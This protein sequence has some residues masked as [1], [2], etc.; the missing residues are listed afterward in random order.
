MRQTI[1]FLLALTML[2]SCKGQDSF[3]ETRLKTAEKFIECL[4][5]NSSDK[6]LDYSYPDIDDKI[7]DK[8][9]R[10]F[11]VNKAYNFIKR[12][13]LPTKDKWIVKYDP[14][15]NFERLIIIIPLF[16]GYDTVFNLLRADIVLTFPPPQISD[17]VYT[18]IIDDD[19]KIKKLNAPQLVDK[20]KRKE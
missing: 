8:E 9:S 19:Y 16:K 6:I 11:Y 2:P 15:N 4:K 3:V 17:K 1:I 13:G 18:Y 12:F 20:T 14:Q 7:S 5:N 10:D